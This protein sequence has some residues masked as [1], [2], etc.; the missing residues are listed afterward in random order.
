MRGEAVSG[1]SVAMYTSPAPKFLPR[2]GASVR[3]HGCSL[4]RVRN[5]P[6]W[7][8]QRSALSDAGFGQ[9][10]IYVVLLLGQRD[11]EKRAG[12]VGRLQGESLGHA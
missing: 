8:A 6:W 5:I 2:G 4:Y 9:P 12:C 3:L 7:Q 11:E 10:K 1:D